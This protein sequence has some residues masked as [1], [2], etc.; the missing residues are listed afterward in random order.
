MTLEDPCRGRLDGLAVGDVAQLVL[1]C[2]RLR[3]RDPDH[4]C[5]PAL[6]R[7]HDLGSD[8]GRGAGDYRYLQILILRADAA[9]LPPASVSVATSVWVPFSTLPVFHAKE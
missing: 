7:L 5:A 8:P 2:T 6:K 4:E 9:V 3:P 1:V